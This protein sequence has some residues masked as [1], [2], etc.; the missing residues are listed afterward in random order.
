MKCS[1]L[2]DLILGFADHIVI[3]PLYSPHRMRLDIHSGPQLIVQAD[4]HSPG[5]RN[6]DLVP[7]S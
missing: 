2:K 1:E 4:I 7:H 3:I 6:T 5:L